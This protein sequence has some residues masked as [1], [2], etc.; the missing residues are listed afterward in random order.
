MFVSTL[1]LEH[2]CIM[3]GII[4]GQCNFVNKERSKKTGCET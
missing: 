1:F 4:H 3:K 2:Y